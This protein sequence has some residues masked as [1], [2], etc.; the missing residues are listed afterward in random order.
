MLAA[1]ADRNIPG[2]AGP[3]GNQ[4]A[5][6]PEVLV[7]DV[8]VK[9]HQSLVRLE[10]YERQVDGKGATTVTRQGNRVPSAYQKNLEAAQAHYRAMAKLYKDV[11]GADPEDAEDEG[12]VLDFEKETS[13]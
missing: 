5:G 7:E 13:R 4:G 11:V 6:S 2:K 9:Y 8:V 12:V 3:K 10:R 1:M